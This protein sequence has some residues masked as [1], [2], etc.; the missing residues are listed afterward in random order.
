[1]DTSKPLLTHR[2]NIDEPRYD[3]STYWGRA[4]HFFSITNSLNLFTPGSELDQ[5]KDIITRY[6]YQFD[7]QVAHCITD[8]TETMVV[9]MITGAGKM[10]LDWLKISCGDSKTCMIQLIIQKR[11]RDRS[12]LVEWQLRSQWTCSSQD[13]CSPSIGKSSLHYSSYII[14]SWTWMIS[15]QPE[16]WYSGSGSISHS[17][18]WLT[19]R[20][21]VDQLL[22]PHRKYLLSCSLGVILDISIQ[23]RQLGLSYVC[24][25]SGALV[26]ALTLNRLVKL[27]PPLIGRFV[28]FCAVAAANCVNIP[29][30]RYR[31]VFMKY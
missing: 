8:S 23:N 6:R 5:A 10:C 27:A 24:A 14:I 1:M 28:P 9:A 26:T 21:E 17:M 20:I 13:V 12:F 7:L 18:L 3:Q 11:V 31:F 29:M 15:G 2:I 30:M 22:S 16:K 19:I 25:T 4:R